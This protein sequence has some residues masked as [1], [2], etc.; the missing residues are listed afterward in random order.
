M[1]RII[2]IDYGMKRC[3]IAVTDELKI[4]AS[5][6][7]TIPTE[8]IFSFLKN[9]FEKEITEKIIVGMPYDLQG[10]PTDATPLVNNFIHELKTKFPTFPIVTI[11]ERYTSKL[12]VQSMVQSGKKKKER[13]DKNNIDKI[14]ASILLENYL[15]MQA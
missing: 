12:A 11:D 13:R 7:Q 2:A 1:P 10:R 14:A 4:I 8:E 3:G 6:L 15:Q 9:Y 5:P